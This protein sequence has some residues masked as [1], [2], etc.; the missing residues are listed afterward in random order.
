VDQDTQPADA[1]ALFVYFL[2]R[3][4]ARFAIVRHRSGGAARISMDF[5][6]ARAQ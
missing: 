6:G 1:P 3:R 5:D 2:V 4:K